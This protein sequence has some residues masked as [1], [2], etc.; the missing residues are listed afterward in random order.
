MSESLPLRLSL[1]SP[2]FK[3]PQCPSP[4][5]GPIKED[6]S[7][8]FSWMLREISP[9][10]SNISYILDSVF[11][12]IEAEISLAIWERLP[13]AFPL[14]D[15]SK[16]IENHS[17]MSWLEVK[18][19]DYAPSK[20]GDKAIVLGSGRLMAQILNVSRFQGNMAWSYCEPSDVNLGDEVIF[21]PEKAVSITFSDAKPDHSVG[22]A[23]G[24]FLI[25]KD[26]EASYHLDV[27][28]EIR[29]DLGGER[30]L[31]PPRFFTSTEMAIGKMLERAERK[32]SEL[33]WLFDPELPAP[34]EKSAAKDPSKP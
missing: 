21:Y 10:G 34:D 2:S 12:S 31:F 17:V 29:N 8:H 18:D 26:G 23:I 9:D 24:Y 3:F 32:K 14:L 19:H 20:F 33:D 16:D 28:I 4:G 27:K 7:R 30:M 22:C 13:E 25:N 15:M 1:A 6:E 5:K 11:N